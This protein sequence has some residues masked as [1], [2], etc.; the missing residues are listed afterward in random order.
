MSVRRAC[1]V[2]VVVTAFL[3]TGST[4]SAQTYSWQKPHAKVL[5]A[6]NLEWAPEPF[7]YRAGDVVRYID[8]EAGDDANDGATKATPWKHHPWDVH[9]SGNAAEAAGAVTYVFKGGVMYRGQLNAD[10]SGEPGNPIRLTWDPSWGEGRPWLVGSERL[11]AR[12]VK[13]DTVDVPPRLPDPQEVWALD[14]TESGLLERQEDGTYRLVYRRPDGRA[15][16]NPPGPSFTGLFRV[17]DGG[18]VATLHLACDPDWQ[19]GGES[20]AMDYWHSWDGTGTVT[21]KGK[22][23]T[24]AQ[25]DALKGF[26]P[27]YFVGGYVWSQYPLFMGTPKP[28]EIPETV[29]MKGF[30]EPVPYYFPEA[31]LF[32]Q[33]VPGGFKKNVRYMIENLPQ[34]LDTADE[35]YLDA[36]TGFLY[37]RLPEGSNPNDLHLELTKVLGQISIPG[38]SNIE[39]SGLRFSFAHH[40]TIGVSGSSSNITVSHCEFYDV[41]NIAFEAA[42]GMARFEPSTEVLDNI[43]VTDC[44]FRNVW[45]SG[46]KISDG[47]GGSLMQP[48]GQLGHAEVLRNRFYNTGMRHA[49]NVQ[50]N[51]P[52]ISVLYPNTGEVAGNIVRRSFGSGI[53]VFGGKQGA[54]GSL[55]I[56]SLD[57]PLI[58]IFVHHNLTEDTA[59]GVNDY[60]GLALWQGGPIYAYSNNI[61]S[62]PGHMPGGFWGIP[63]TNLSYPLYLDGAYK[64]YCFNNV[65]WGRSIQPDDPYRSMN[66]AYFM[67]FGFLNQ[68]VNNT[69]YR[70]GKGIGGSSGNRCDVFGNVFSEISGTF[71]ANNRTGDPSL[72]GGGDDASSGLRGV[73]SLAYGNNVF[74]GQAEA[75]AILK[76]KRDEQGRPL[77]EIP[78]EI[79]ARDVATMREQ[80]EAF[81]L[82]YGELGVA[83]DERPIV[84]CDRPEI[85]SGADVDFRLSEGSVAADRGVNYFIPFSLYGTVGEWHFTENRADPTRVIDYHWYMSEAH[86]YRMLYE[87]VPTF[88]LQLSETS[89]DDYTDSPS[90]DW[91]AGALVFDGNR[92]GRYS[93]AAMRQDFRIPLARITGKHTRVIPDA[94]QNIFAVVQGEGGY[95]GYPAEK[96]KTLIITTQNLLVEANVRAGSAGT[97]A[98]KYDENA[99]YR[100]AVDDA[101]K[102]VFTIS[103]GGTNDSVATAGRVTDGAWHHVLAEVDRAT[104]RMTIYL[105]GRK[106]GEIKA[107]LAAEASLDCRADFVV[108]EGLSGALDF[109]RVCRGTLADARTDIAELYE[110]QTNGPFKYDFAGN[111]PRGRRDAG[112]L[113]FIAE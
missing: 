23:L 35:F 34:Y 19:P 87:Q 76:Q 109:L 81:P 37:L 45:E 99:G 36:R 91:G 11:P 70:H 9:A 44:D 63:M 8:Y 56:R 84:G 68:F 78:H 2:A 22:E 102:A 54:L 93:D 73:P 86:F 64:M 89:L 83:T 92:S 75:G 52:T 27:D 12:W 67:V 55:A 15:H 51:V 111:P 25:A 79:A 46:V 1:I 103:S 66:S 61:G 30:D 105:D 26:P 71:L 38:Q 43:R 3:R 59:L 107:G 113:E 42:L 94:D 110:W 13:A 48:F 14:L 50:S 17:S 80:M 88:D 41:P 98:A 106:S 69:V 85:G 6:G 104:G 18:E 21:Y 24:G 95:V 57:V 47:S 101:G 82:R 90:E 10:E 39:I 32:R 72:V 62:S 49:G 31:G 65:I 74:H 20:F 7:S 53:V 5:P 4:A 77:L 40:A 112:A 33:G 96:R 16:W 97:I 108:G 58:R 29:A 60:G 28:Y 100:L